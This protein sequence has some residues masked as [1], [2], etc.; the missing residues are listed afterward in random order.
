MCFTPLHPTLGIVLGVVTLAC[1]CLSMETHAM[2]LT[3]HSFSADVIVRGG[4]DLFSQQSVGDFYAL[5]ASALGDP[6][7]NF[8]WSDQNRL[9][10]P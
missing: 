1:S 7:C 4:L 10:F 5:C 8:T 6:L 3:A 9:P 2:K